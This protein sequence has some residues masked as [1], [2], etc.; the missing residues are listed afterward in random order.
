MSGELYVPSTKTTQWGLK[1]SHCDG[2]LCFD[3]YEESCPFGD[4]AKWKGDVDEHEEVGDG[5]RQ[6]VSVGFALE[7][8][9]IKLTRSRW[10]KYDYTISGCS[11]MVILWRT[12]L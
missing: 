3:T 5:D 9:L 2:Q 10:D 1:T 11:I 7:L 4:P 12:K 6:D 8:V